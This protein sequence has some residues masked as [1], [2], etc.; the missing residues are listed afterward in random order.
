MLRVLKEGD[1]A[2]RVLISADLFSNSSICPSQVLAATASKGRRHPE[3][4]RG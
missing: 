2:F 1:S 3:F 4:Q